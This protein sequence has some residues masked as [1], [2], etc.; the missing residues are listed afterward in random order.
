MAGP[1]VVAG[2]EFLAG[3][4]LLAGLL[5]RC[6][7]PAAGQDLVCAVS[8]GADSLALLVLACS[9]GC[10]V[11][12]IHV[13]H[14]LRPGSGQEAAVV[15]GAA[16][17]FQARFRAVRVQVAP[18]ANLEAR[19]R[20]A[21]RSV[22]PS[23][24]AT[25]HTADDQAETIVLNLLRGSALDGLAGMRAGPSHPI[26]ALRR[27]ETAALCASLG[28]VPVRDPTNDDLAHRRNRV[29]HQVMPLLAAVAE[30]DV[31]G[32]VARQAALLADDA[33]LLEQLAAGID[34]TDAAGL[35]RA[36]SPLAR[37]AL[38]R[39]LRDDS[40]HPPSS[41]ALERVLSVARGEVRACEVGA[42]RRVRRSSGR[43][44]LMAGA[45]EGPLASGP[46]AIPEVGPDTTRSPEITASL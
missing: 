38:R 31:A 28:L 10:R 21:R 5:A 14:G 11:T 16:R 44:V 7:F 27:S 25:G 15:A 18:G 43:L 4:E 9:A 20:A 41:E 26:L 40:G 19:A 12:A 34:P 2:P 32:L 35:V 8:G 17:R 23:G 33:D 37:R 45:G 6:S 3:P 1:G 24:A 46:S 30:R 13:D 22:L 29:R 42:G 39:W 36:P